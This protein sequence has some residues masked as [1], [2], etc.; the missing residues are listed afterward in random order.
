MIKTD[1]YEMCSQQSA[2]SSQQSAVSSQQHNSLYTFI[3]NGVDL[4]NRYCYC[5][6]FRKTYP[7]N[8]FSVS[9]VFTV[10]A[11]SKKVEY[12]FCADPPYLIPL[13]Y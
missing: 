9:G 4:I 11:A 10:C 8:R 7:K 3:E 6:L 1:L 13:T 5:V 2:V 12:G